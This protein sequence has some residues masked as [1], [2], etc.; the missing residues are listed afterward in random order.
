MIRVLL[1]LSALVS[2]A[3]TPLPARSDRS[4]Y[5]AAEVIDA[6]T[7]QRLEARHQ[8]LF[9]RTGVAIVVVTVPALVDETIEDLAVRVGTTWGVGRRG[10]D[11]GL[12][13]A[14]ARDD[15]KIFVATGYGTEGYLP[16]GRVGALLDEHAMP[17]L[18]ADRFAEGLERLSAALA[19]AAAEEHGIELEGAPPPRAGPP[20]RRTVGGPGGL[21]LVVLGAILF[22]YLA[23]RHPGLLLLFLATRGGRLGGGSGFGGGGGFEG[24]GGGGFG[25]GGAGRSF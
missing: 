1:L 24:F 23:V 21:L 5:D 18:R 12:V 14:F 2:V 16:D 6:A 15:R 7:E 4:I 19:G 17:A 3:A 10:E 8:A 13:V 25:G 22:A 11:R 20:P 9:A